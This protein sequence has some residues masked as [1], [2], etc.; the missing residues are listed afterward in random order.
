MYESIL[1]SNFILLKSSFHI[2]ITPFSSLETKT[3][4]SFLLFV[5]AVKTLK[6]VKGKS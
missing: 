6:E 3:S 4:I 1:I 2:L 5:F